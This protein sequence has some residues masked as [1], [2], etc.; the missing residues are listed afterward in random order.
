MIF[1]SFVWTVLCAGALAISWDS[2]VK[3][4]MP[5]KAGFGSVD[6]K[7][8]VAGQFSCGMTWMI[9]W[10]V[11]ISC[12]CSSQVIMKVHPYILLVERSSFSAVMVLMMNI[13]RT[14]GWNFRLGPK[15]LIR[16]FFLIRMRSAPNG[17]LRILQV[18]RCI[19]YVHFIP[20]VVL[21][22]PLKT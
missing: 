19:Q 18:Y 6:V 12:G 2:H 16:P 21:H 7:D 20:T 8:V 17:G 15:F 1:N 22:V 4:Q 14:A 3:D 9:N 11:W 13:N 10:L 5:K